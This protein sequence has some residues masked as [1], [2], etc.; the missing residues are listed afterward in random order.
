MERGAVDA[1]VELLQEK[2]A[3]VLGW[4]PRVLYEKAGDGAGVVGAQLGLAVA[5]AAQGRQQLPGRQGLGGAQGAVRDAQERRDDSAGQAHATVGQQIAQ[6]ATKDGDGAQ[7]GEQL[8]PDEE[9]PLLPQVQGVEA[10]AVVRSPLRE[11]SLAS[12]ISGCG[13]RGV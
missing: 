3:Q 5:G 11:D 8:K 1:E 4:G 6:E 2:V 13:S 7:Q 12:G 10:N 9:D